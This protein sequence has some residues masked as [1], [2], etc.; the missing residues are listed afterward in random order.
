MAIL[1]VCWVAFVA[2]DTAYN[3]RCPACGERFR[4]RDM[5]DTVEH[6]RHYSFHRCPRCGVMCSYE[7]Y[8]K[9]IRREP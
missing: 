4:I 5:T 6:Q 8:Y 2:Q 7:V 9:T 3:A 1:L